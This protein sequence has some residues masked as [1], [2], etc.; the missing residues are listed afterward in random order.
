MTY[1]ATLSVPFFRT[2]SIPI[3][4]GIRSDTAAKALILAGIVNIAGSTVYSYTDIDVL[5]AVAGLAADSGAGCYI[6]ILQ[7]SV[8]LQ[9]TTFCLTFFVSGQRFQINDSGFVQC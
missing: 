5:T 3:P 1:S 4:I 7:K 9:K 2:G 8:I 6:I